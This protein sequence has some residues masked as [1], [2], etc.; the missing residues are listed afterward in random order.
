MNSMVVF[1]H[2]LEREHMTESNENAALDAARFALQDALIRTLHWC[3]LSARTRRP[4]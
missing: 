3:R 2:R 4:R 1:T